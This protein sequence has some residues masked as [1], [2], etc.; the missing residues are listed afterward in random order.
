LSGLLRIIPVLSLSLLVLKKFKRLHFHLVRQFEKKT[1]VLLLL[2]LWDGLKV[3]RSFGASKFTSL[4]PLLLIISSK[5]P[6]RSMGYFLKTSQ[7]SHT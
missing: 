2:W 6:L 5:I 7:L 3:V 1:D 4:S